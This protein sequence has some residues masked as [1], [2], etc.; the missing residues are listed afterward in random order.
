MSGCSKI[1]KMMVPNQPPTVKLTSAP[2]DTSG[3]YFYAY[4]LG[5]I[6]NDPDGRVD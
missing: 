5:W 6:G 2:Y 4:K 1:T 3:R